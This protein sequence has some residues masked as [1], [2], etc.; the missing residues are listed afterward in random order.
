MTQNLNLMKYFTLFFLLITL[1]SLAQNEAWYIQKIVQQ[2]DGETEVTVPNGRVDIVTDEYAI[3]VEWADN[4]KHSIGQAL[5]YAIQTNKK[6]GIILI[7]KDESDYKYGIMLQSTLDYARISDVIQVWFYPQ[8][9]GG[10]FENQK[11][12]EK[13]YRQELDEKD[14]QYW[15][16]RSSHVRHN[17]SCQHFGNSKGECGSATDGKACKK[18]GG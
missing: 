16:T 9:F 7:M 1:P 6:A 17:K 8:D 13:N 10:S 5:W 11:Q 18:C 14:C 12:E 3:E 15:I 2:L 4:W